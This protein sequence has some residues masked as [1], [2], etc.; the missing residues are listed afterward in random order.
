MGYPC[1]NINLRKLKHNVRYILNCCNNNHIEVYGVTKVFC[2]REEICRAI[3]EAGINTLADSRMKNIENMKNLNCEKVLLRIP[4]ISESGYVVKYCNM[5]LNSELDTIK[6]LNKEANKLHVKHKIILMLDLGDLREG[7]L[8]E[9]IEDI[10]SEVIKL[11]NI[12][13]KGIGTN[14]TCYGGVIPDDDNL[15]ALVEIKK[16]LEDKFSIVIDIVSGGNSSSLYK[17]IN[18]TMIKGINNLRLGES[19]LL[20]KETAFGN[21][22]ENCF[23][24]VFLLCGEIIELKEKPS[25]PKGRIGM[26]AFGNKPSFVDEGLIKRAIINLGRQDIK[27]EGIHTKDKKIRI[28]GASSDHL[29]LDITK[30]ENRYKLGDKVEFLMDYGALLQ[31]MT[32]EYV[33]KVYIDK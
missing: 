32:S 27:L 3:L 30:A 13:L 10:V 12:Q 16:H 28:L 23:N 14:L 15:G 25:L 9:N 1:I 22:I 19:L 24:D 20:G 5:S 33:E 6:S 21:N 29:I 18:N 2:A 8:P 17:V 11:E 26:D 7:I 4:S 31:S